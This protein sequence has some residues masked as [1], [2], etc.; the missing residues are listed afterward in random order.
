MYSIERRVWSDKNQAVDQ[1]DFDEL[2]R[3]PKER[4][5]AAEKIIK[6]AM[7]V[8]GASDRVDFTIARIIRRKS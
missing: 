7:K 6:F 3:T 5:A 4:L 8:R 2:K 1:I